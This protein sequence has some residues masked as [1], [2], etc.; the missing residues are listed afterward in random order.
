MT[1]LN[2]DG[3]E[4]FFGFQKGTLYLTLVTMTTYKNKQ[5]NKC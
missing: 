5:N 2:I 4:N 3:S 1:V